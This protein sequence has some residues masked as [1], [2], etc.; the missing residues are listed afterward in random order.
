MLPSNKSSAS[1]VADFV[2]FQEVADKLYW[3]FSPIMEQQ[4]CRTL[5]TQAQSSFN[6][7]TFYTFLIITVQQSLSR[8]SSPVKMAT[9]PGIWQFYLPWAW[10]NSEELPFPVPSFTIFSGLL[11]KQEM[12]YK[13]STPFIFSSSPERRHELQ[14]TWGKG[15]PAR[16]LSFWFL[17]EASKET[18]QHWDPASLP[19]KKS[20][21]QTALH[22]PDD[23][24]CLGSNSC[25][26]PQVQGYWD[27]M[28]WL[29][30]LYIKGPSA[31][32]QIWL[33]ASS[34]SRFGILIW[35]SA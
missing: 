17:P 12:L 27:Q 19:G 13:S 29:T 3:M 5:G 24:I 25:P 10:L 14:S 11:L 16:L 7:G 9:K 21:W 34:K 15:C 28:F 26:A 6:P 35:T 2:I 31:K 1:P 8:V 32:A 4:T 23:P 22:S 30:S 18:Q 20:A 33:R